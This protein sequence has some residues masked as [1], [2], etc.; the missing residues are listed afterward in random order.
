MNASH[1]WWMAGFDEPVLGARQ[2]S[3]AVSDVADEFALLMVYVE[4]R[5]TSTARRPALCALPGH[6]GSWLCAYSSYERLIKGHHGEDEIEYSA[7]RGS[8]VLA[9]LPERAGVWLDH[10]LLG[11]RK[12]ILPQ[13]DP[14]S[15]L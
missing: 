11:G 3:A 1:E 2:Q 5:T 10:G 9:L 7:L 8:T 13:V 15:D 4:F 12:I 6:P 14:L